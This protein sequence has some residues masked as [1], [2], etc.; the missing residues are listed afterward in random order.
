MHGC[1]TAMLEV[2]YS[3]TL[4]PLSALCF[5]RGTCTTV[6]RDIEILAPPVMTSV[7]AFYRIDVSQYWNYINTLYFRST[8]SVSYDILCSTPCFWVWAPVDNHNERYPLSWTAPWHGNMQHISWSN[9]SMY[10]L[11]RSLQISNVFYNSLW[12][13][14]LHST[15]QTKS[16]IENKFILY[17]GQI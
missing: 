13:N 9:I 12:T 11:K 15:L 5:G 8:F 16:K 10:T 1:N 6:I 17:H 14:F 2:H 3:F 4:I 7:L